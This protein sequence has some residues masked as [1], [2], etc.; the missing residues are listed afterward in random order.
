MTNE[1]FSWRRS[2]LPA[3][4]CRHRQMDVDAGRAAHLG[5]E[6]ARSHL[7]GHDP[8]TVRDEPRL[9]NPGTRA[10]RST[11]LIRRRLRR[12]FSTITSSMFGDLKTSSLPLANF[13]RHLPHSAWHAG[14]AGCRRSPRCS[15]WTSGEAGRHIRR[16]CHVWRT[17]SSALIGKGMTA[18]LSTSWWPLF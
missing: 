10:G 8:S 18:E 9:N 3:P 6:M 1:C 4:A 11:R 15:L 7:A 16:A 17:G 12:M 14:V 2:T 13:A 5:S